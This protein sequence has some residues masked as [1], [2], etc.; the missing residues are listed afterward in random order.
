MLLVSAIRQMPANALSVVN[1]SKAL[2]KRAEV[3]ER[4]TARYTPLHCWVKSS[5]L[6]CADWWYRSWCRLMSCLRM[7]ERSHLASWHGYLRLFSWTLSTWTFKLWV[8]ANTSES[9]QSHCS[10]AK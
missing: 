3:D 4:P 2:G 8:R 5:G 7:N 6:V 9:D 10:T 1:D